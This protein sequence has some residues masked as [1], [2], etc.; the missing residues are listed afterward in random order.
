M[1]SIFHDK[2]NYCEYFLSGFGRGGENDSR[3]VG[4]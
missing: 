1:Y 4:Y 3:T 2:N